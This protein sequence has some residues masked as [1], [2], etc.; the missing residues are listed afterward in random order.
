MR[1]LDQIKAEVPELLV[2]DLRHRGLSR[3]TILN[4]LSTL[5]SMLGAARD[6]NYL[7]PELDW[8]K[9]RLPVEELEKPQ[10]FF[11]PDEPNNS[12]TQPRSRGTSVSRSCPTWVCAPVRRWA[13]PVSVRTSL[14]ARQTCTACSAGA[15][16][17]HLLGSFPSFCR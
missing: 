14:Q 4:A 3:K 15:P 11:T 17:P 6:W 2:N 8:R 9:L 10:R 16:C 12:S 5:A 7:A 1:R 13:S